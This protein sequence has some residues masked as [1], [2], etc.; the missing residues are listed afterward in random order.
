MLHRIPGLNPFLPFSLY[1]PD[2]EP[3]VFGGRVYLYGS[4]DLFNGSYCCGE[5]HVVSAPVD[6][7]ANWKDHGVSFSVEDVPWSSALLYAPD[8]IFRNGRY[9]LFFCLS[10]GSEGV[11]ESAKPEGSFKNAR[12]ITLDG[13][14]IEGIDP[15][16][17]E[18]DGHVYYTWGQFE[19]KT[20][21]LNEDM[22]SL[23]P[24][25]VRSGVLSNADGREGFH[26]GSSLRR[27]GS[28]FCMIYA[29]EY[30]DEY[31]HKGGRPTK[32]D[33]AVSSSPYGPYE[34]RGTIIDN[35][36]TDPESW[37]DHGSIIKIGGEWFVFYHASSNKT[38]FSRRA[39]V[40]RIE[41]DEENGFIAQAGPSTN[42][43]VRTLLPEHL[44]SPVHACRFFGGA[45]VTETPDG[46]FPAAGLKNG[47]GFLFSPALY[48][49]GRYVLVLT[50]RAKKNVRLQLR[51]GGFTAL[52]AALNEGDHLQIARF[53]FSSPGGMLQTEFSI[54]AEE[55][56]NLCEID[57]IRIT[58]AD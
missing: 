34:R 1:I 5:Y 37:N 23:K 55:G 40:E 9:Y 27:I 18:H 14:P 44:T 21:E 43:F 57:C 36:G 16:V 3:K 53:E 46:R 39:R 11:A 8:V 12:R 42:G 17:L 58:K 54:S 15:S 31:P 28:R 32:L 6:D 10:D 38:Q 45:Y 51:L 22:C 25:T 19:L 2:G 52:D 4:F 56:E 33:Y 48:E 24:E 50:F 20:A 49:K 47:A 13:V 26:E 29:S 30:T 7:L 35:E 41:V